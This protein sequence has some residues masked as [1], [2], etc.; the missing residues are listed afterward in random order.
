[1]LR[2]GKSKPRRVDLGGGAWI[3][4]R[5]ATQFDLDEV[6]AEVS[7]ALAGIAAGSEAADFLA[8]VLGEDFNVDG[9]KDRDRLVAASIRLSEIYLVMACQSGWE[10]IVTEDGKPLGA[11]E[12]ASVALLLSDPAIRARVMAVVNSPHSRGASRGKRIARLAEWRG[13]SPAILRPVPCQRRALRPRPERRGR[14]LP[15]SGI[16]APHAGRPR[17]R[18]SDRAMGRVEAR[19]NERPHR[20]ARYTG[21]P[22]NR[23]QAG[24]TSTLPDVSC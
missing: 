11:P 13:G 6:H 18:R 8:G 5:P 10:G 1:M 19:R 23:C 15:R 4:A 3:V 21:S 16:C 20:R 24:S 9:L 7:R 17:G 12:P 2:L 14:A 22:C